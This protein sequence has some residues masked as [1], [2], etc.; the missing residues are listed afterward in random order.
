MDTSRID[1]FPATLRFCVNAVIP[2]SYL[3]MLDLEHDPPLLIQ[4][5]EDTA[6]TGRVDV[7]SATPEELAAISA[8]V[9]T[10]PVR[11]DAEN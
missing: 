6:A 10:L 9:D 11:P 3:V 7:R 1:C 8:W 4:E 5:R 2:H